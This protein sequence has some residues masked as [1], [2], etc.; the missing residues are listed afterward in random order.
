MNNR[1]K[2]NRL[3]VKELAKRISNAKSLEETN[4]HIRS[5]LLDI[6]ISLAVIA[7]NMADTKPEG[8]VCD[9]CEHNGFPDGDGACYR[10]CEYYDCQYKEKP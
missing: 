1:V 5:I 7:D 8:R 2:E 6:S 9:S 3:A 10:C 4:V